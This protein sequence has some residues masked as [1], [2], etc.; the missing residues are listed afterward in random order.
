[1]GVHVQKARWEG[2]GKWVVLIMFLDVSFA[3]NLWSKSMD[4]IFFL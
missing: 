2:Y 3:F 4:E 1:M